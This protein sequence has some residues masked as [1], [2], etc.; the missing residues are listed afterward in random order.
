MIEKL[1]SKENYI[2]LIRMMAQGKVFVEEIEEL[3]KYVSGNRTKLEAL[4]VALSKRLLD[5]NKPVIYPIETIVV[6]RYPFSKKP[7][8]EWGKLKDRSYNDPEVNRVKDISSRL[9]A[10]INSAFI[11]R[12]FVL[13]DIDSENLPKDLE[14]DVKTRRGYHKIFYIPKYPAVMFKLGGNPSTKYKVKCGDIDIE[15]ISGSNYLISNPIQSRY[16]VYA[17]SKFHIYRY[18]IL[19]KRAEICFNSAD[20]TPIYADIEDVKAFLQ[21]LFNKLGCEGYSKVLE[22]VGL[23]KENFSN[24]IPMVRA[25]ESKFNNN[26]MS[27]VGGLDY[28]EFKNSLQSKAEMLPTCLRQA[29]FGGIDKGHRYFHLRF[30]LAVLPFFVEMNNNNIEI[31]IKDF[32]ERTSSTPGEVR[33]WLYNTY[34]FTGKIS[35]EGN[36]IRTP[37]LLGVPN[38]AWTDFEGLGYC[39]DCVFKDNCKNSSGSDRRKQI[40]SYITQILG[41]AI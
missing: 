12:N 10:A 24:D 31:F 19:S 28:T 14:M 27:L 15:L 34:Y 17:D 37:S 26:A 39:N 4:L 8:I 22:V 38:E 32:A 3:L 35:I 36:D 16:I 33:S 1:L 2:N 29:L 18:K 11:G 7:L 9:G 25:K 5:I 40:V 30:L 20:L 6:P 23:E 13:V 41:D 21:D